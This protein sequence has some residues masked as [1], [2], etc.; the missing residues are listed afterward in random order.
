MSLLT[1][2]EGLRHQ[3]ERLVR[4]NEELKKLVRLIR[5]NQEL[6]SAIKTQAGGLNIS[7]L[8]S[9]LGEMAASPSQRQGVFL[10]PSPAA[11]ANEQVL[12]E[13]GVVALAPL[14]DMLSSPQPSPAVGSFVS[15]MMGPL[16]TLLSNPVPVSQS[17]PLTSLLTGPLSSHLAS[18]LAMT[19]GGTLTSLP[20][21]GPLSSHLASPITVTPGATLTNSL[22]LTST[23]SLSPGSPLASTLAGPMAVSQS[24]PL[25]TP[26]AGPVAVSLSSPLLTS[27]AA[28]LG[29][30]QNF[31]ASPMGGLIVPEAPGVRLADTLQ[32][33]HSGPLSSAGAGPTINSKGNGV[34]GRGRGSLGRPDPAPTLPHSN[35][36]LSFLP[37]QPVTLAS[38]HPQP[39]QEPEPLSVTFVGAPLQ[40]STPVGIMAMP[41]P[42]TALYGTADARIQPGVP[43]GQMVPASIP[44]SPTASPAGTVP[45]PTPQAATNCT[46]SGTIPTPPR[47]QQ[48]PSRPLP[49]PHSPPRNPQSSP[50]TSSSPA[51]VNDT[52][53]YSR[54][55]EPSRKGLLELERKMAHRKTS[56]FP[57]S[58]RESKLLAWE[59]LVGEIAFQL[60]RR[61]L[62]SIFPERVRLYGFTVSNIP[63]KII[64]ASLNPSDHKLDE[65]LCQTLTQRYVSIMNR[66]QSLGYNGRVHP[67]L[68][69]QLVNAYGILRERPELAASEGGSYT[70][71]FLQRVLVETVHPSMLTDALLLLSCLNQLA[72]DDGKPMFIW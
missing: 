31:L 43:Q 56:K 38:E 28:P 69:E 20:S 26:M 63:E 14:A 7:G 36:L 64:Q 5:E 49:V 60:D 55:T 6:K 8:T 39:I 42:T 17:S 68:T 25:M 67:A 19:P 45:A 1:N 62:S 51:S 4:E 58:T 35:P 23:G 57:D 53:G 24:S 30:S 15:S 66:L 34:P 13:V 2:Y 9:G 71:D 3:I 44:T 48:S 22:G 18:P 21:T 50:R 70:V 32:G 41:G 10:P 52:R 27:A 72:H 40:T 47:V 37:P 11:A 65:E 54:T 59:R 46:P 12:E 29:V 16:N 61:I 33:G